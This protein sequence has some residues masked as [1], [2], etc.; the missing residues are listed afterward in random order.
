MRQAPIKST[1]DVR[2]TALLPAF[3]ND[4]AHTASIAELFFR[5]RVD[6]LL[7]TI[8]Q[9]RLYRSLLRPNA[10]ARFGIVLKVQRQMQG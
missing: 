6:T 4:G 8:Q 1:L 2:A 3:A 5:Q 9:K 7:C 10:Q